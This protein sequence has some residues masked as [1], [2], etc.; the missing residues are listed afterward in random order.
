MHPTL[1]PVQR[2]RLFRDL[3]RIDWQRR[4]DF[5][6][7]PGGTMWFSLAEPWQGDLADFHERMAGR[8][9]RIQNLRERHSESDFQKLTTDVTGLIKVLHTMITDE[10]LGA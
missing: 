8:L 1:S 9:Q 7:A 5:L 2:D 3:E 6:Y 10:S 4:D